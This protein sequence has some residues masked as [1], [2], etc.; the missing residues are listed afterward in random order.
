[1]KLIP[2]TAFFA[3]LLFLWGV[4]KILR[5]Q[6]D[7]KAIEEG[8]RTAFWGIIALFIIVSIGGLVVLLQQ[9]F[10][11]GVSNSLPTYR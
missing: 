3:L 8:R 11:G 2:M 1:M 7:M 5:G 10:L 6:G 9:D 4:S